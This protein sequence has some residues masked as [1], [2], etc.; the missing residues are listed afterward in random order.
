[1]TTA[2]LAPVGNARPRRRH[3]VPAD[4]FG[5]AHDSDG[6]RVAVVPHYLAPRRS[7]SSMDTSYGSRPRLPRQHRRRGDG[8]D[9]PPDEALVERSCVCRAPRPVLCRRMSLVQRAG[10]GMG[11]ATVSNWR[12]GKASRS[13]TSPSTPVNVEEDKKVV[14]TDFF[15]NFF[16]VWRISRVPSPLVHPYEQ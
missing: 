16:F 7:R 13:H 4:A 12:T 14:S 3:C 8:Q 9:H 6:T 1:M 11:R 15:K 2:R 10:G 5:A